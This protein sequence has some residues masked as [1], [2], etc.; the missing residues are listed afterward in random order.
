MRSNECVSWALSSSLNASMCD[1]CLHYYSYSVLISSLDENKMTS[2]I[3]IYL[4]VSRLNDAESNDPRN[5]EHKT[6]QNKKERKSEK[7]REKEHREWWSIECNS[8]DEF[9]YYS[10]EFSVFQLISSE[11]NMKYVWK[12]IE[13]V[14]ALHFSSVACALRSLLHSFP[15]SLSL[16]VSFS[17]QHHRSWLACRFPRRKYEDVCTQPKWSTSM[18]VHFSDHIL[19]AWF[20]ST[21]MLLDNNNNCTSSEW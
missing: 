11:A 17:R 9:V 20:P 2:R 16:C 13:I 3:V 12:S 6:K 15:F 14:H 1:D 10:R 8:Y 5:R 19:Y 21:S 7:E 4:N 18:F